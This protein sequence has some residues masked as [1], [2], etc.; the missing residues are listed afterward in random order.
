L[1]YMR[2]RK[3][4]VGAI[5]DQQQKL[6]GQTLK[7]A[8]MRRLISMR[9]V[10]ALFSALDFFGYPD[11]GNPGG[12]LYDSLNPAGDSQKEIEGVKAFERD[13]DKLREIL[14]MILEK[15]ASTAIREVNAGLLAMTLRMEL[16]RSGEVRITELIGGVQAAIYYALALILGDPAITRRL[17]R[18]G[19]PDCR[20]F[21]LDFAPKWRKHCNEAHRRAAD[22][23]K[24][25]ARSK[26]WREIKRPAKK[27]RLRMRLEER[28]KK[29]VK[30]IIQIPARKDGTEVDPLGRGM[31]WQHRDYDLAYKIRTQIRAGNGWRKVLDELSNAERRR[32]NRMQVESD[33]SS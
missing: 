17:R 24:A 28:M 9:Q 6:I 18:C 25:P 30:R 16:S 3:S 13:R 2:V 15:E 7:F 11:P 32:L 20:K 4:G 12:R 27:L 23:L 26:E 19:A 5:T 21:I 8:N 33:D 1:I 14:T 31:D 29:I 10:E 22:K